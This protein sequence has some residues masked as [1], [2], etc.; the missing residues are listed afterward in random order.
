MLT[1]SLAAIAC[2]FALSGCATTDCERE[3]Q[4]VPVNVPVYQAPKRM[5]VTEK[6]ELPV[7]KISETSTDA[8]VVKSYKA[9]LDLMIKSRDELKKAI[10]EY[11]D[12]IGAK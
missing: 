7:A 3:V 6:P 9:S 5:L 2:V 11:L 10:E 12:S 8:D 4:Y 1:K